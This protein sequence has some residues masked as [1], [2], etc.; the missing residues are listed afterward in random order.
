MKHN[1]SVNIILDDADFYLQKISK[2]KYSRNIKKTNMLKNLSDA[3]DSDL[4]CLASNECVIYEKLDTFYFNIMITMSGC[5][6]LKSNHRIID[7]VDMAVNSM[8]SDITDFVKKNVV[9]NKD[10]ITEKYGDVIVGV[11]Y[12]PCNKPGRTD[13]TGTNMRGS[14]VI[15]NV[16]TMMTEKQINDVSELAELTNMSPYPIIAKIP[17]GEFTSDLV[18][19]T[20]AE[21][22]SKVGGKSFSGLSIDKVEGIVI[23][24]KCKTVQV[25]NDH[26]EKPDAHQKKID[27]YDRF[28][29]R[30]CE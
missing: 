8:Y 3:T 19:M 24:S 14:F 17:A 30:L 21:I 22:V 26:P 23:K 7:D 4:K 10:K 29:K 2:N 16:K 12:F 27:A 1:A 18:N 6:V 20:P 28:V 25:L 5:T 15:G 9:P 13:Y 11:F